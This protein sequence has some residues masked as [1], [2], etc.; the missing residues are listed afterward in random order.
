LAD[1]LTIGVGLPYFPCGYILKGCVEDLSLGLAFAMKDLTKTAAI[2][3]WPGN[4]KRAVKVYGMLAD[5]G[6]YA[7]L[8]LD[9]KGFTLV[10]GIE[11]KA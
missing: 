11:P 8:E 4:D 9:F 10:V 7:H 2:L 6:Y 3:T 1:R 5:A